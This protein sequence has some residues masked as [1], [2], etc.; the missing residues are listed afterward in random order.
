MVRISKIVEDILLADE[1]A[2]EALRE[3]ILNLSAYA[4]KIL[5]EVERETFKSVRNGTI[6]VVLSRALKNIGNLP[7]L[8]TKV[9]IQD[10]S[11]K[12]PLFEVAFEKTAKNLERVS[13]L[14][15]AWFTE[16][17]F[18]TTEGLGEIT[19]IA[20]ERMKTQLL[21]HFSVKPKG[22]YDN[23]V[24]ITIRFKGED[25]IEEPNIIFTLVSAIASKRINL[26]E[27]VSTYTEISFIVRKTEMHTTT[28][29]LQHF[30]DKTQ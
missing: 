21:N 27:I 13:Q 5:P 9:V 19:I 7:R 24:A 4:R 15:R 6:V 11:I 1:I 17:F 25:Y 16:D 30:F 26:I 2:L 12:S 23:L 28:E 18:T 8:K 29:V 20:T 10:L 22:L 3:G 14:P